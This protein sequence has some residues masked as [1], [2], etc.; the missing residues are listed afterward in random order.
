MATMNISLPDTMKKWVEERAASADYGNVS[1]YIRDLIRKDKERAEARAWF[2]AEIEKGYA[3]GF[4]EGTID[5][6][7]AEAL[8]NISPGGPIK[9]IA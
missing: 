1:D 7:F 6:F 3:S 5:E 9:K 4:M 8:K 2:A